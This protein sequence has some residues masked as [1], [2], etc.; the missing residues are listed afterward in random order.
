MK[1]KIIDFSNGIFSYSQPELRM[2]PEELL[3]R[4]KSGGFLSGSF[5]VSSCD[6]RRI[7]GVL[8]T[9]LAGLTL[10]Q[11][12]FF[13]RAARIEYEYDAKGLQEGESLQGSIYIESDAGEYEL[14]VQIEMEP[15]AQRQE[16]EETPLPET[17]PEETLQKSPGKGRGRSEEWRKKRSR[18]MVMAQILS[19]AERERRGVCDSADAAAQLRAQVEILRKETP[20]SPIA[21]LLDAWVLLKEDR[22]EEAGWILKKYERTRLFQQR[23]AVTRALFL[24]INCLYRDNAET[25]AAA[26]PQLQKLYQKNQDLWL[27]V[28]FLLEL[29]PKLKENPRTAYKLLERQFRAG[30][31]SRLIYQAAW[32]YLKN[33]MALFGR[34]DAFALQTCAWAS[35]HG[36]LNAETSILIAKQAS[37]LKRWSPLAARLLK[38]CYQTNPC[39]ETVGAVCAIHIRGHR[40]DADAFVWYQKGVELD[41]KIT[42]LYEYFMYSLPEDYPTLLPRQVILYFD[43]HNTLT[44]RQ[45]AAF[46]CNLARYGDLDQPEMEGHRRKLQEFLLEQLKSR[47][48][49]ESLAWLYEHCLLLETLEK[50]M[51]EA[52]ADLLFMRKLSCQEK[53]IRQVEVRY[54]QLKERFVAPLS[55]GCAFVPIYTPSAQIVL[56]DAQ[57]RRYRQTV[58]YDMK[59][60]LIEP[61][62]LQ[63]CTRK[64]E[65]H[66]G[67]NLYLLDGRGRHRLNSEN[68][69][70]ARRLL[71]SGKLDESYEQQLKLELLELERKAGRTEKLADYLPM[72]NVDSLNRKGQA[73]CIEILILLGRDWEAWTTLN[74]TGCRDV[75]PKLLLRLLQRLLAEGELQHG[76]LRPFARLIFEK[77]VY[78]E[79]IVALLAEECAGS[80]GELLAV[81]KAG[82]QFGL[83]FPELEEQIV[84]QALFTERY[85]EEV[86]PVFLSLDERGGDPVLISAWL[87]YTAWLDFVKERGMPEGLF[88]SLQHHL[89]WEDHLAEIAGLSYLKQLSVLLLLSET[90]KKLARRLLSENGLGRKPFAFL[91]KL[92]PY[93]EDE[94]RPND[95][96]VVEYRGDP[97][98]R[99][100]LHYVLEYHGKK[101]FDYIT[102]QLFPVYQGVFTK[103]FTLFYGERLTWF[104]TEEMPDGTE[105]STMS[106]TI[107]NREEHMDGSSRYER[108][109]HMQRE[110]DYRHERNL[111]RMMRDYEELSRIT[112]EQFSRR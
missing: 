18:E 65:D 23:D 16:E 13:G 24:Y 58:P 7:R 37:R 86:F 42:N 87:N 14:P 102:E 12:S 82:E 89:L 9:R 101:T 95:S 69:E 84:V 63:E 72:E 76:R 60:L 25:T 78:T 105:R 2:E 40:T 29:D 79:Q 22:A 20:N 28:L 103:S 48:L 43:Y 27:I 93:M 100:V 107:E 49:N 19:L 59:R 5:V 36:L 51:L 64:L 77:G 61:R 106:K 88:E 21:P 67:L 98:H 97:Q 6:E 50:D 44:G 108:L 66:T 17:V 111:G 39:R 96:T 41:A 75:D 91:G 15:S 80:T 53:R 52:L 56:I 57:G 1:G 62:F 26:I 99:V 81:W 104:F 30:A 32:S 8:G 110:Y 90:Q 46:Y 68:A 71:R 38:G 10:K 34:L 35:S 54:E 70:T 47:R 73:S 3:L 85:I 74:R 109:C 45:K 92:Y 4:T 33:D 55:G 31:R 83:T 112:A 11:D 94:V